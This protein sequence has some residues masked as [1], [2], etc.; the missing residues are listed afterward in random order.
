MI[1]NSRPLEECL[2]PANYMLQFPAK[3][4][5]A[6]CYQEK[7]VVFTEDGRP[8]EVVQGKHRFYRKRLTW[9]PQLLA[10]VRRMDD[11]KDKAKWEGF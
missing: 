4:V 10:R 11:L 8:W 9:S 5:R 2:F 6:M 1:E 3:V 7:L